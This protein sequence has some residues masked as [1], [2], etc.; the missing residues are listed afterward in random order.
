M[1]LDRAEPGRGRISG[2]AVSLGV[3]VG[4]GGLL[5]LIQ[6]APAGAVGRWVEMVVT[7]TPEPEAEPPKPAE[8]EKPK[9][10]PRKVQ[11]RVEP[12]EPD[13]VPPPPD[14]PPQSARRVHGLNPNSMVPGTNGGFSARVGTNLTTKAG[15]ETMKPEEAAVSWAAASVAPK[16]PKPALTVPE[17]IR[18]A[19]VH[20]SVEILLD[21]GADGRVADVRV[22]K[23]LHAEADVAC[24]SAWESV[25]CAA[26][27]LGESPVGVTG[28]PHTCTF[29]LVE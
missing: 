14:L 3:H 26:G 18:K 6:V 1:P 2:W 12:A 21:V 19:G 22:V 5:A 17:S 15:P 10:E 4:L 11:V 23:P 24:V 28:L 16:C 20:G 7:E 9:P 8:P 29:R 13:P 25:R 27:R